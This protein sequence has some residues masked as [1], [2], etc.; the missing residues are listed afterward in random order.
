MKTRIKLGISPCLLGEKVR[1][2]GGH[3]RDHFFTDTLGLYVDYFPFCPEVECGLGTPREAMR[4]EG[5]PENPRVVTTHTHLDQTDRMLEWAKGRVRG[6]EKENLMGFIF[7]SGS[8]S[9]GMERV[10]VYNKKGMPS[11]KG[12]R[13]F[14]EGLYGTFP[15]NPCG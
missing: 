6:L 8:P 2:D 12:A 14:F 10:K 4:L 5:D 1:Y 13:D 9:C 15:A 3:K 11:I 7:K